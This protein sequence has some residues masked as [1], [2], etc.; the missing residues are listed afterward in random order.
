MLNSL[1]DGL[2]QKHPVSVLFNMSASRQIFCLKILNPHMRFL[3]EI[4]LEIEKRSLSRGGWAS[5]NGRTATRFIGNA[6]DTSI[7]SLG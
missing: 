5:G 2:L 6:R 1:L 7:D 4:H 3:R